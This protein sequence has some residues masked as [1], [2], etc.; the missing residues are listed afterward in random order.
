MKIGSK[1]QILANKVQMVNRME[2]VTLQVKVESLT[3]AEE[4]DFGFDA[5]KQAAKMLETIGR[6]RF[7]TLR[8]QEMHSDREK[9]DHSNVRVAFRGGEPLP[10]LDELLAPLP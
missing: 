5:D 10:L 6:V 1:Q 3:P 7:P 4:A 9:C 2:L 8:G